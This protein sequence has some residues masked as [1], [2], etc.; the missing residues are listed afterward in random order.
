MAIDERIEKALRTGEPLS[1]LRTIAQML[2]EQG[3]SEAAVTALFDHARLQLGVG[4]LGDR[5]TTGDA[6]LE[7]VGI[8]QRLPYRLTRR[9]DD[10]FATHLH[11]RF[12]QDAVGSES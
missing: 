2:I 9:R 5:F 7:D 12:L 6:L 1:A 4:M 8:V 3:S 11:G 10:L